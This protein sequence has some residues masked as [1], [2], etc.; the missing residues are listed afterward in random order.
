MEYR[1]IIF[2]QQ[3]STKSFF[4]NNLCI[5]AYF[6]DRIREIIIPGY[7]SLYKNRK[8]ER[9]REIS[10]KSLTLAYFVYF[11]SFGIF[12]YIINL[13]ATH[14]LYIYYLVLLCYVQS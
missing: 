9:E 1:P 8:R 14:G 13:E 5:I 11:P 7:I 6:E 10:Q 2:L 4:G 12:L 3:A